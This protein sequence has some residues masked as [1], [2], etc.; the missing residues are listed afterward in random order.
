MLDDTNGVSCTNTF[1]C[2]VLKEDLVWK[3][4]CLNVGFAFCYKFFFVLVWTTHINRVCINIL[5][6]GI[7]FILIFFLMALMRC[8]GE[9]FL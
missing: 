3:V 2:F 1:S 7:Q 5:K 8:I 4:T 6:H 9:V